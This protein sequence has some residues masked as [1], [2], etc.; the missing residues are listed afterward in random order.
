MEKYRD[1]YKHHWVIEMSDEG[2]DEANK[3]F[4]K[5]FLLKMKVLFLYVQK[6]KQKKQFYIALL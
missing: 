6:W 5:V 4:E 3:Y 1:E 2:I